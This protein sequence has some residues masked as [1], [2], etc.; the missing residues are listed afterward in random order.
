MAESHQRY[1]D[2][3][4][5]H[6]LG[7]LD[8]QDSA[9]FRA[10]LLSCRDCRLRVAELRDLAAELAATERQ[11]RRRAAVATETV[12]RVD[13]HDADDRSR[14]ERWSRP[15]LRVGAVLATM[16]VLTVLFWN[17]HLRRVTGNYEAVVERQAEVLS[18][19]A[20]G[21]PLDV[22]TS[23]GVT[24]AAAVSDGHL[25]VSLE[26]FPELGEDE[27]VVL[28]RVDDGRASVVDV[29]RAPQDG[30]VPFAMQVADADAVV[31]TVESA[32]QR[33]TAP[34]NRQLAEVRLPPG[35]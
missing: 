31:V 9:E 27:V 20:S 30:A 8:S 14:W 1:E 3:A 5:A 18:I 34:G 25:A 22:R 12:R 29:G 2:L 21:D 13:H 10:H 15:A 26:A 17:Y 6:V 23:A 28:W 24:G 19:L 16:V 32:S 4:L 33:P 35:D 11:E 7:G